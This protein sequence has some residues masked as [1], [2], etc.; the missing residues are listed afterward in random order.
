MRHVLLTLNA[1]IA[2]LNVI[3]TYYNGKVYAQLEALINKKRQELHDL[4]QTHMANL[5]RLCASQI[6]KSSSKDAI[7]AKVKAEDSEKNK[8]TPGI[9]KRNNT[10]GKAEALKKTAIPL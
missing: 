2:I 8:T 9:L 4:T 5:R 7:I 1:S 6:N 10:P 3:L